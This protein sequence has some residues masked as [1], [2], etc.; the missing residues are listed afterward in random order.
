MWE[1]G[2]WHDSILVKDRVF[3]LDDLIKYLPLDKKEGPK[4]RRCEQVDCNLYLLVYE[5]GEDNEE[6]YCYFND[7]FEIVALEKR[8]INCY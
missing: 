3:Y 1:C 2:S 7:K 8:P 6:T 5:E 4:P